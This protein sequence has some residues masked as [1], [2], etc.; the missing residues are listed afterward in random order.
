MHPLAPI[1]TQSAT[2]FDL[3]EVRE[4]IMKNR[5]K[6]DYKWSRKDGVSCYSTTVAEKSLP[7]A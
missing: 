7:V 1:A 4:K 3:E 5:S 2:Q 6:T